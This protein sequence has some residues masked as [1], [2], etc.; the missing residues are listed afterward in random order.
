MARKLLPLQPAQLVRRCER[1]Q[2]SFSWPSPVDARLN[3]LV[4]LAID[5]GA[6]DRLSRMELLSALIVGASANGQELRRLLDAYRGATVGALKPAPPGD[7][8]NVIE[9]S[10]RRPGPRTR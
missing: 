7:A 9:L 5:A 1:V 3:D 8:T 4:E 6:E 10:P 2:A